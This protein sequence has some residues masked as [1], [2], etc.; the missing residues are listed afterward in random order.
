[1]K[2]LISS[3]EHDAITRYLKVWTEKLVQ[4]FQR[5]HTIQHVKGEKATRERICGMIEK[6]APDVI[7]LNGH[8][9]DDRVCGHNNEVLV[10]LGNVSILK[11]KMVHAL[12]CN[13]AKRLGVEAVKQGAEGYV[14]YDEKFV[15]VSNKSKVSNPWQDETAKLFL[16]PAF[17]AQKALLNK[18]TPGEAVELARKAYRRSIQKALNSDIQSDDDQALPFLLHD[19]M[20]LKAIAKN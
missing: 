3:P 8:G 9:A 4:N 10:D 17:T 16:D 7:L 20:H 15:L 12:S 18:K 2:V 11:Q 5:V 14:G 1:M 19:M 13:S 6:Q